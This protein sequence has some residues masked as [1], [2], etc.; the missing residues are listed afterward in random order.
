MA[1][2]KISIIEILGRELNFLTQYIFCRSR[3]DESIGGI[4]SEFYYL[5]HKIFTTERQKMLQNIPYHLR[6]NPESMTT[7]YSIFSYHY[8]RLIIDL[9]FKISTA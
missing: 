4:K 3:R 6:L 8:G 2:G 1:G 5:E 9:K 7:Y